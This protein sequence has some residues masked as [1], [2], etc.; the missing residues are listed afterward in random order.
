MPHFAATNRAIAQN[1]ADHSLHHMPS[2]IMSRCMGMNKSTLLNEETLGADIL[3]LCM[4]R[5]H[6]ENLVKDTKHTDETT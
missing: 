3:R 5:F 2:G 4:P 1:M 6:R